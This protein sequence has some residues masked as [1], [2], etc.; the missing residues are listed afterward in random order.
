MYTHTCHIK[1]ESRC[2]P[3]TY[4]K[5]WW[6]FQKYRCQKPCDT[7]PLFHPEVQISEWLYSEGKFA[8]HWQIL[9]KHLPLNSLL[10]ST[11]VIG[12]HF[13]WSWQLRQAWEGAG[14]HSGASKGAP[15]SFPCGP[16]FST[17]HFSWS[18]VLF[19]LFYFF[20][21]LLCPSKMKLL[22]LSYNSGPRCLI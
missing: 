20:F 17:L 15:K 1:T 3:G 14:P 13:Q 22:S 19:L 21:S 8:S 16:C 10:E 4:I 18:L 7:V 6:Q 11:S 5:C 2:S 12:W 9:L